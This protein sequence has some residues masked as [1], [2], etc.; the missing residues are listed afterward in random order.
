MR[1]S[2]GRIY[3]LGFIDAVEPQLLPTRQ[4]DV[5]DLD[6]AVTEGRPGMI[7]AGVGYSSIDEFVGSIQLQH[8]NLFGLGQRL[9]FLTEWGFGQSQRRNYQL[10][11]TEPYFLNQDMSLTLSG[12][13]VERIRDYD[14]VT[15][16]Y[17]EQREGGSVTVGP[18]FSDVIFLSVGYSFEHVTLDDSIFPRDSFNEQWAY[19][20]FLSDTGI[21]KDNVSSII[22]SIAYDTRDVYFDPTRGQRQSISIRTASDKLGGDTNFIKG[23]FKSSWYFPIVW[24]FVLGVNFTVGRV[25]GYNGQDVPLYEKFYI[26]GADTVRGYDYQQIGYAGGAKVMSVLNVEYKFPML[27]DKNRTI[28]QGVF[29]YD[30]GGSWQ[31]VRDINTDVGNQPENLRS[32]VGFGIRFAT[33]M[34]PLRIDWGYGLNHK[35]GDKLQKFY[36]SIGNIF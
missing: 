35:E 19:A 2:I 21:S 15:S 27:M 22:T 25:V 34:F 18:R 4:Q 32:G 26:G 29:F 28:L 9:N 3:N 24:R 5:M 30:V 20:K 31:D 17:K 33:P 12:F 23:Y 16:A 36:F 13:H 11:W 7:S 1:S 6:I 8:L 14:I 10:D